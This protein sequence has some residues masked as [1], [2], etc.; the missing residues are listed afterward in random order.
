[1]EEG[2]DARPGIVPGSVA[3]FSLP[4]SSV[5]VTDSGSSFLKA[6]AVALSE[7]VAPKTL[8]PILIVIVIVL[9]IACL[10]SPGC[11]ASEE[12]Q[13]QA[14]ARVRISDAIEVYRAIRRLASAGP[15]VVLVGGH[16]VHLVD[17]LAI[18]SFMDGGVGHRRGGRCTMPVLLAWRNPYDIAG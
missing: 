2:V 17:S 6:A 15:S 5:I 13:A 12:G 3:N 7:R 18:K 4:F 14:S 10:R 8:S 11:A 9:L 16:V 1:M